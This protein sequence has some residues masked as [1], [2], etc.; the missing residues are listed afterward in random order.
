MSSNL[1]GLCYYMSHPST[2][3][4]AAAPSPTNRVRSFYIII[5]LE[6][7]LP[8]LTAYRTSTTFMDHAM[9]TNVR[10]IAPM[11]DAERA[12]R[13]EGYNSPKKETVNPPARIVNGV[14]SHS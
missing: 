7:T 14:V 9:D 4:Y 1:Y 10:D 11:R 3:Y 2:P 12:E 5:L 13:A 6:S 8:S